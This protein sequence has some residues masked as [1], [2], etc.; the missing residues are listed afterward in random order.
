[1]SL[2]PLGNRVLV[3]SSEAESMTAGGIALPGS[4]QQKATE[5]KVVAVGPG[6]VTDHGQLVPMNVKVGDVV[7]YGK[8]AGTEL[9]VDGQDLMIMNE[10][11]ILA[12]KSKK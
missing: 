9:K 12:V 8:Y 11:D 10:T 4:A 3:C 5:G 7:V 1:M 6:A 2:N